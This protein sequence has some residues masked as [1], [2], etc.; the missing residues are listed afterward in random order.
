MKNR[1]NE[2]FQAAIREHR[3]GQLAEAERLYR[4]VLADPPLRIEVT[5]LLAAL[6]LQQKR[7]NEASELLRELSEQCPDSAAVHNN[8]GI[9]LKAAGR[10]REAGDAFQRA[11]RIDARYPQAWYNLGVLLADAG[12]PGDAEEYFQ[13]CLSL[14][15]SDAEALWRLAAALAAQQKWQAAEA[16]YRRLLRAQPDH[17]NAMINLAGI[18]VRCHR[19][20]EA[21]ALFRDVLRLRPDYA[22]I[23]SNLSYVAEQQGRFEEAIDHARQALE[24]KPDLADAYNNW[25]VALRS[26]HRLE[27]A[28]QRFRQALQLRPDFALAEFNLATTRLLAGDFAGGWAGYE[29]R[30]EAVGRQA[31]P[32]PRPRWDGRP[33]PGRRLLVYSDQGFGDAIQ[34]VRFLPALKERSQATII[35]AC[36]AELRPL[37]AGVVGADEVVAET[38]WP[39][40]D[41]YLPLASAPVVLHADARSLQVEV[42]YVPAPKPLRSELRQLLRRARRD[43]RKV[44]LVWQGNPAQQRDT[45]RSCRLDQWLE[46][47]HVPGLCFFSLQKDDAGRKQLAALADRW[48]IIDIG[49]H[50]RDFADTAAVLQ[51][52]D[53]LISVDTAAAHLAGALGRPVWTLLCHTPDWRW[54]LDGPATPWYP[55]MRL[56]RQA[57]WG[58]WAEVVRKVRSEL[59]RWGPRQV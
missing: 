21:A 35:L 42:P 44:G 30:F 54:L 38:P 18:L 52:L 39:S 43:Q 19:L 51:E 34:F 31:G 8:L 29:R 5:E 10:G 28:C 11:L 12:R 58:D 4:A 53:L 40:F 6:L 33:C 13:R 22:E 37:L 50:L 7:F 56:F 24:L 41:Y 9:A 26:L 27:E 47:S 46:W 32:F 25:G 1:T 55:T 20:D 36:S 16:V 48:Q 15:P 3:R 57:R 14:N 45:L 17:V 23:H 49:S 2:T 59:Q